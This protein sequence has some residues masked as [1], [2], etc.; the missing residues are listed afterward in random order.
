M[1]GSHFTDEDAEEDAR[2]AV[3]RVRGEAGVAAEALQEDAE[4]VLSNCAWSPSWLMRLPPRTGRLATE[5][6]EAGEEGTGP[7]TPAKATKGGA[8]KL[9]DDMA[10]TLED[11]LAEAAAISLTISSRNPSIS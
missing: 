5:E 10:E 11:L 1:R 8:G 7:S 6:S 4:E 3:A 9:E 2:G